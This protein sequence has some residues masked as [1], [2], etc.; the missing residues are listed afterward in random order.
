MKSRFAIYSLVTTSLLLSLTFIGSYNAKAASSGFVINKSIN[1]T[2]L[3]AAVKGSAATVIRPTDVV[4]IDITVTNLGPDKASITLIDYYQAD[5]SYG[6]DSES[7]SA[8]SSWYNVGTATKAGGSVSLSAGIA[9]GVSP[10]IA[11]GQQ[12]QMRYKV[13]NAKNLPSNKTRLVALPVTSDGYNG[14]TKFIH[15]VGYVLFTPNIDNV[16]TDS[17]ASSFVKKE[18]AVELYD[19]AFMIPGV[20]VSVGTTT[21][22]AGETVALRSMQS[23]SSSAD[24]LLN[25]NGVQ[26]TNRGG[27]CLYNTKATVSIG[28]VSAGSA[29]A[30]L[31]TVPASAVIG[32]VKI[33]TDASAP[34]VD[35]SNILLP[36]E[37]VASGVKG[38]TANQNINYS[39][40]SGSVTGLNDSL[41]SKYGNVYLDVNLSLVKKNPDY[42]ISKTTY[43]GVKSIIQTGEGGKPSFTLSCD[44]SCAPATPTFRITPSA[45]GWGYLDLSSQSM[46]NSTA[47]V[48]TSKKGGYVWYVDGNL[49]IED[50]TTFRK[51]TNLGLGTIFVNGELTIRNISVDTSSGAAL[52]IIA[53]KIIWKTDLAVAG[54]SELKSVAIFAN[55][56]FVGTTTRGDHSLSL[57]GTIVARDNVDFSGVLTPD[58]ADTVNLKV[59]YDTSIA[60]NA[61]PGMAKLSPSVNLSD[62]P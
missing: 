48:K 3:T 32:S 56:D 62:N 55:G 9:T 39:I 53:N 35:V 30:M 38:S 19:L 40:D 23:A 8:N 46:T 52:G 20:T 7:D 54:K 10:Q 61:P 4:Q 34:S 42:I 26:T 22:T 50:S 6:F 49:V 15:D 31:M 44:V 41:L 28:G 21:V 13:T 27:V 5:N 57:L 14:V 17:V 1:N 16:A 18:G 58:T 60:Q 51:I 43:S 36:G 59:Q 12:L 37:H 33:G 29:S 47:K 24:S 2:I 11:V 25:C 45:A